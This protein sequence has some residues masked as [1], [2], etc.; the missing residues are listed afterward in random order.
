MQVTFKDRPP[1]NKENIKEGCRV[2]VRMEG[3]MTVGRL[4]DE[5]RGR[6]NNFWRVREEGG[7]GSRG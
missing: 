1:V 4:L 6:Y 5:C 3:E 2:F 7:A